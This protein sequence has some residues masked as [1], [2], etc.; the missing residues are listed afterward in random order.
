MSMIHARSPRP[1]AILPGAIVL[2]TVV[3]MIEA[4]PIRV[5]PRSAGRA[6]RTDWAPLGYDARDIEILDW[7][8]SHRRG[9]HGRL[10]LH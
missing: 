10:L 3:A 4:S 2:A 6:S 8:A 5:S 1:P 7:I 9:P